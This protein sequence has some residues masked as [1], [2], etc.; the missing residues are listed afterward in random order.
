M[1][2]VVSK[3]RCY[4]CGSM[5]EGR[6]GE[7]KYI[8]CGLKSVILKDIL[9]YHC[10]TCNAL[11]PDIPAAGVLHRVIALRLVSKKNF[12]TGSEIRFLRKLCGYSVNDFAAILGSSKSVISRFEKEGCGKENDRIIRL[13]VI[14]KMSR[15]IAGQPE[16]ILRNV[17]IEELNSEVENTF[18]LMAGKGRESERYEIPPEELQR[19]IGAN[20]D[21]AELLM[22]VQ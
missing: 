5:M 22:A 7:Y 18:K 14:A 9:V 12:L 6:K 2:E 17:T 13:L 3:L 4:E 8:E 10:N 15:E 19:Y 21:P 20:E 11:I 16:R 1:N